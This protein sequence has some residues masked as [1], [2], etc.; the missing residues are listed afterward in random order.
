MIGHED[1]IGESRGMFLKSFLKCAIVFSI[2]Q[3][4]FAQCNLN[5]NNNPTQS[6]GSVAETSPIRNSGEEENV[7]FN[8]KKRS[9]D[10]TIKFDKSHNKREFPSSAGHKRNLDT[11]YHDIEYNY[12]YDYGIKPAV[13]PDELPEC[14]LSRS[15]FYLSWWVNEDGSLKLSASNRGSTSAGFIDLSFNVQAHNAT[16]NHVL[17]MS[18]ENPSD[19]IVWMLPQLSKL[20]K[21]YF[22]LLG[23]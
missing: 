21:K 23:H 18:T 10:D 11:L 1:D 4:R 19:V 3:N 5:A 12:D 14:I 17:Q 9:T 15:E 13:S 7:T 8:D 6:N 20:L 22:L 2:T 16:I